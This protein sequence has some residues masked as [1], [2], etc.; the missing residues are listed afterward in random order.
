MSTGFLVIVLFFIPTNNIGELQL[1]YTLANLDIFSR[2]NFTH[3]SGC[4][5]LYF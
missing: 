4:I 1:F 2:L 5:S 3:S